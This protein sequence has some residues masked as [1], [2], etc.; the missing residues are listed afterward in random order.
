[1]NNRYQE[2][3]V[4][5]VWIRGKPSVTHAAIAY[6]FTVAPVPEAERVAVL[7]SGAAA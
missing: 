6:V 4:Q 1:M 7:G 5:D 2:R 3:S